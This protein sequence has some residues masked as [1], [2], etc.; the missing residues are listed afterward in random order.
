MATSTPNYDINYEDEQ[1]KKVEQAKETDLQANKDLYGGMIED[2]D[3][4]Y[5]KLSDQAL[6]NADKMAGIQ[7]ENTDFAIKQIEQQKEK[8]QKDY[9]KEQSGAYTDWQKQSNQYGV[10]AE[11]MAMQGM[12]GTGFSETSQVSMYNAYQN[13]VAVARESLN[14]LMMNYNN[15]IQQAILQNNSALAQIY[16][17]ANT[18]SLEIL[19]QGFQYKNSLLTEQAD[20]DLQ[21]KQYYS[22]E[23]QNVLNQMNTENALAESVRQAQ[24]QEEQWK[25]EQ[26]VKQEQW[27]KEYDL[28]KTEAERKALIEERQMQLAENEYNAKYGAN[29]IETK[30]ANAEVDYY[31]TQKE[32]V[33]KGDLVTNSSYWNGERAQNVGGFGYFSNGYQPKGVMDGGTAYELKSAK[34]TDGNKATIWKTNTTLWGTEETKEI[35]VWQANGKYYYWNGPDNKYIQISKSEL[36]KMGVNVK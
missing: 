35:T 28:A 21:L 14:E 8:A 9:T 2:V 34:T 3:S 12:T 25:E 19:L 10:K 24:I 17:E 6:A 13:R 7:Q 23:W 20:K 30:K 27:Q 15:N 36:K 16:N 26:R 33:V 11:Q 18:K 4:Y 22:T 29:G 32:A 31:N 1:F 5:Q